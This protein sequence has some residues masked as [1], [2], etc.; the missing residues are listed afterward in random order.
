M[1]KSVDKMKLAA[2]G[3]RRLAKK[4]AT[5][6][7][8]A[9]ALQTKNALMALSGAY[10]LLLRKLQSKRLGA[11][12]RFNFDLVYSRSPGRRCAHSGGC[13]LS[14]DRSQ[15]GPRV[16]EAR[17]PCRAIHRRSP[18]GNLSPPSPLLPWLPPPGHA[19][20]LR[21]AQCGPCPASS[22]KTTA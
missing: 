3:V 22:E 20:F 15:N 18:E 17:G 8:E 9:Y 5:S 7:E 19:F 6:R 10:P 14:E 21:H 12:E 11:R 1:E 4:N 2:S 16:R 13:P